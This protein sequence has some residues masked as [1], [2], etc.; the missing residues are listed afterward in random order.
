[1]S[2]HAIF[3]PSQI[4]TA[5]NCEASV[6]AGASVPELPTPKVALEGSLGH[7]LAANGL[8]AYLHNIGKNELESRT[9]QD[10]FNYTKSL[11]ENPLFSEDLNDKAQDCMHYGRTLIEEALKEDPSAR[12]FVERRFDLSRWIKWGFGTADLVIVTNKKIICVDW[13]F[14]HRPVSAQSNP[15]LMAYSLGAVGEFDFLYDVPEIEM[16]IFQPALDKYD[17]FNLSTN[18]LLDWGEKDLKPLAK[19]VLSGNAEFTPG[20][21][22]QW[23]RARAV[24]RARAEHN[25]A[26]AQKDFGKKPDLL[27]D[28]ELSTIVKQAKEF[29]TWAADVEQHCLTNALTTG[30]QYPGLKIVEGRTQR[31]YSDVDLVATRLSNNGY[32]EDEIF[33]KKLINLT[34][35]KKLLGS[36]KFGTLVE[37]LLVKP[38]G[39]PKLVADDDKRPT[40][41]PSDDGPSEFSK[42]SK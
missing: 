18:D 38:R 21:H 14:G 3:S 33:D 42:T 40:Y 22:C 32:K 23:C 6:L 35:M 26:I 39:A 20:S 36:K 16:H 2:E 15:Q 17:V 19:R 24:C 27:S 28:E 13:K 12:V 31:K 29:A 11:L 1:M 7:E 10:Q 30:Y 25:L 41:Q 8:E 4:A 9:E 5:L 37:D 34:N